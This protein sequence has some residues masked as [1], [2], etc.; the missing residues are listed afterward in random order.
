MRQSLKD[1]L[2]DPNLMILLKGNPDSGK[3]RFC[4][5]FPFPMLYLDFD[6]KAHSMARI[7]MSRGID[8]DDKKYVTYEFYS[9]KDL[10]KFDV[11]MEELLQKEGAGWA[12][13]I[14][15]SLTTLATHAVDYFSKNAPRSKKEQDGDSGKIIGGIKLPGFQEYGGEFKVLNV[16]TQ[17]FMALKCHRIL[18]AHI[19]AGDKPE[20]QRQIVTAG[21]KPAAMLPA[22]FPEIFHLENEI[23]GD[24]E[25]PG[26]YIVRTKSTGSDFARTSLECNATFNWTNKDVF[27]ILCKIAKRSGRELNRGIVKAP[28]TI[29]ENKVED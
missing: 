7:L 28:I 9:R 5:Y 27:E 24:P 19:V 21:K 23:S 4:S 16:L 14:V 2:L 11:R 8:I 17:V 10:D 13:I 29:E 26:E 20:W 15:D 12:T 22:V 6:G 3:T 1:F 18:T 25:K